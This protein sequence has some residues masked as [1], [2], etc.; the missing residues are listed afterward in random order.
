MQVSDQ[1]SLFDLDALTTDGPAPP[2]PGERGRGRSRRRPSGAATETEVAAGAVVRVLPDVSGFDKEFD[3]L[4]RPEQVEQLAVGSVVRVELSGRRV[5]GWVTGVDLDPPSGVTLVPLVR[6]LSAGPD[7]ATVELARWVAH[8]WAGRTAAVLKAA[9]PSR[10]VRSLPRIARSAGSSRESTGR[11][12]GSA[13]VTSERIPPGDDLADRIAAIT[14]DAVTR[15]AVTQPGGTTARSGDVIVVCPRVEQARSIGGVLRRAG[16]PVRDHP[17]DWAG[18]AGRGGIVIG[19]RS[20]VW[21]RVP[22]LA[23]VIV[24]D[25]HDEAHQEERNPTWHARDVAIERARRS[26]ASCHLLSPAPTVVAVV[27]AGGR[28]TAPSRAVERSGW[29]VVEV[30]DRRREE[31]SR[32]GLFSPRLV[33]VVRGSGRVLCVLNRKGRSVL[34]ACRMCGELVRTEDGE[35]LM[36]ERDGVLVCPATGETRPLV[37]AHCGATALKRLRLGVTRAAEELAALVG[38]EVDEVSGPPSTRRSGCRPLSR[39]VVGTEA[40]LHGP[41]AADAVAF[42]DIDA[43]LLAPRFR[44]AEQA[45]ALLAVAARL[46]G[47]RSAGGR[48]VVQTRNPGHRVLQAVVRADPARFTRAEWE[49]REA[50]GLPPFSALAELSGKGAAELAQ[51]LAVWTG[52]AAGGS[53]A[54]GSAAGGSADRGGPKGGGSPLSVLGPDP[55]GRFLVRAA[56]P[57][58]LADAL[59]AVERPSARVRV[60]VDPPRA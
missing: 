43:E 12:G 39:V 24:V 28:V 21:A 10:R 58:V 53:A 34:S 52:P 41:V 40:V 26:G 35:R 37:C 32:S 17:R 29:P 55:R 30:V 56:T 6:V 23:A 4:A 57:E 22:D 48:V 13:A 20:A 33:D 18:A 11:D 5:D 7:A 31:P 38:E 27:A 3:Y 60:A 1:G 44:A 14:R 47:S 16:M 15:D 50:S 59:V 19:A 45:M 8:R 54:G 2:S 42:L 49:V 36:V 25:E 46:V 51:Q 9:T